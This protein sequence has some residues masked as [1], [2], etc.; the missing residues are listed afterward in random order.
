MNCDELLDEPI[1]I[2]DEGFTAALA[3]DQPSDEVLA[4]I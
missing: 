4:L 3:C 2:I 1:M